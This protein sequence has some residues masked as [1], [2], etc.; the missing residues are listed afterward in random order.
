[1]KN[2]TVTN[3][4][5][6]F[7]SDE[8]PNLAA[9]EEITDTYASPDSILIVIKPNDGYM[10]DPK[11]L[12]VLGEL[13]EAAWKIPYTSRVDSLINYQHIEAD[14][15]SLNVSTLVEDPQNLSQGDASRIRD[16]ALN[17]SPLVDLLI[18]PDGKTIA[19]VGNYEGTSELYT[20]PVQGGLPRRWTYGSE[21]LALSGFTP[22]DVHALAD[23]V[24]NILG[25][26]KRVT[27]P[28]VLDFAQ[29]TAD[30]LEDE[31]ERKAAEHDLNYVSLDG[32]IACMV[33]GAGLAMATMDIIK[34]YGSEPA[35][36]LDVGGGASDGGSQPDLRQQS[37]RGGG[38]G[39]ELGV[40]SSNAAVGLG[41]QGNALAG[42]ELA[43]EEV[44]VDG[45]GW[46]D[47]KGLRLRRVAGAVV[48]HA[49]ATK[50]CS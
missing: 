33:N 35:N 20:M 3:D 12:K 39:G 17:D 1:M 23:N 42:L 45:G 47:R 16:I 18:S 48:S 22:D 49:N 36:F 9:F 43:Q 37:V 41:S 32:N 21:R 30:A 15:D 10:T 44:V 38:N 26:V 7:F 40:V 8:N 4:Y 11:W 5:R 27:Q 19:F 29:H 28:E 31:A 24:V 34:L 13:T 46:R 6:Y 14:E 50:W 2:L 25:A